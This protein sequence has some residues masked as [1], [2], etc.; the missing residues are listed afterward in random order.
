MIANDLIKALEG[1]WNNTGIGLG[2]NFPV[3]TENFIEIMRIKD[4]H[5]LSIKCEGLREGVVSASEWRIELIDDKVSMDHGSYVA[6][7]KKENNVYTLV[8]YDNGKEIRHRIVTLGDKVI[9]IREFFFEGK[10]TQLDF[11]YL[12]KIME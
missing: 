2:D 10:C 5:T 9:F 12:I 4:A 1:K 6:H 7:G 8:G 3:G 11:S